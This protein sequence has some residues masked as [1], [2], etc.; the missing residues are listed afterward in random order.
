[1]LIAIAMVFTFIIY[2]FKSFNNLINYIDS[3]GHIAFWLACGI[4]VGIIGVL[5]GGFYAYNKSKK[6]CY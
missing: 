5:A 2:N 3:S 6:Q 4:V 1:M